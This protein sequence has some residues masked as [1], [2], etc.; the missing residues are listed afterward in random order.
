LGAVEGVEN[1]VWIEYM[2]YLWTLRKKEMQQLQ[3]N[4]AWDIEIEEIVSQS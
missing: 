2:D 4:S 1:V 3:K